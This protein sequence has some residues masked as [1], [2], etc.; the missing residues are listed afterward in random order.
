MIVFSCVT[1][2]ACFDIGELLYKRNCKKH[3]NVKYPSSCSFKHRIFMRM[4][5]IKYLCLSDRDWTE[6]GRVFNSGKD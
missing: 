1:M 2:E 5:L 3:L 6:L 4:L